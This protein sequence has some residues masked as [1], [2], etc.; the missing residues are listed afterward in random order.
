MKINEILINL[1]MKKNMTQR[2]LAL[3][4]NIS[5]ATISRI[6]AG[7][8]TPDTLTLKKLAVALDIDIKYLLGDD[9]TENSIDEISNKTNTV[10]SIGRGGERVVYEISDED[11]AIVNAFIEKMAKKN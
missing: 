4:S 9:N 8:V 11:A 7:E 6:E 1:R 2:A 3:K 5:N 10:V